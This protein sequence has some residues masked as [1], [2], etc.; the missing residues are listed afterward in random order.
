MKGIWGI[1]F[2]GCFY[3][4]ATLNVANAWN[5]EDFTNKT[6][7]ETPEHYGCI[8]LSN[9]SG[10]TDCGTDSYR[11]KK[12]DGSYECKTCPEG[13]ET[14]DRSQDG[15][16]SCY[17]EC[18]PELDAYDLTGPSWSDPAGVSTM[19][20]KRYYNSDDNTC[21]HL[22]C[23]ANFVLRKA[24][25][26][27]GEPIAFDGK[28]YCFACPSTHPNSEPGEHASTENAAL[29]RCYNDCTANLPTVEHS[30]KVEPNK[31][32][33]PDTTC[34]YN[35]ECK[36]GNANGCSMVGYSAVNN[37]TAYPS[38]KP[39]VSGTDGCISQGLSGRAFYTYN[40]NTQSVQGCFIHTDN[41]DRTTHQFNGKKNC[42][43]ERDYG[44]CMPIEKDC[45]EESTYT[46]TCQNTFSSSS[47]R[48]DGKIQLNNNGFYT[49]D[50]NCRCVRT[51]DITAESGEK[52]GKV[53]YYYKYTSYG[54]KL[55]TTH[56]KKEVISCIVG[57]CAND[58]DDTCR[59]TELGF[60]HDNDTS[61]ECQACPSKS[62]TSSEGATTKDDCYFTSGTVFLDDN[63]TFTIPN[64]S[65][66]KVYWG[67]P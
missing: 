11:D 29:A 64:M 57:Y 27:E 13:F 24:N 44:T 31:L 35:V 36:T 37:G 46:Q 55:E 38:C 65:T 5:C 41:C 53:E 34:K 43:A 66:V 7:C 16:K 54:T 21:T 4:F 3:A 48:V 15:I 9:S 42:N 8:Y 28:Y 10:C 62:T 25:T 14:P 39:L 22:S 30:E 26:D 58:D 20:G 51:D 63:G 23:K 17:R 18:K 40:G 2:I 49:I 12:S 59:K 50:N 1:I 60:Y 19:Y 47:V 6:E 61:K 45:K 52:I 67:T 56:E 33:Y 32:Y